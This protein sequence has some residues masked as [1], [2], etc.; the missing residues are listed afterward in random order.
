MKE[1]VTFMSFEIFIWTTG[2]EVCSMLVG[3]SL[4]YWY[5]YT[6]L[7]GWLVVFDLFVFFFILCISDLFKY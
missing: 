6:M 2:E 4:F 3:A 1:K 7:V 5:L